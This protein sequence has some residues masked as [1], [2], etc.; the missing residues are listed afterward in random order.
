MFTPHTVRNVQVECASDALTYVRCAIIKA[1]FEDHQRD[2]RKRSFTGVSGVR[3]DKRRRTV[4]VIVKASDM[5]S[6]AKRIQAKPDEWTDVFITQC[7]N[8]LKNTV[9]QQGQTIF[10]GGSDGDDGQSPEKDSGD[11]LSP[12]K[13]A[14]GG[15]A[16]AAA[17][18]H[19]D[20]SLAA[21]P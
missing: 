15:D 10:Y 20:G 3:C 9:V 14:D 16:D 17:A 19:V 4:Y 2:N 12:E 5:P 18:D 11:G 13:S 7:A 1:A 6:G 21:L 8:E